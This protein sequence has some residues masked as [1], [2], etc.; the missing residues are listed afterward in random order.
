MSHF[1]VPESSRKMWLPMV[2]SHVLV[3]NLPS[4]WNASLKTSRKKPDLVPRSSDFRAS[5]AAVTGHDFPSHSWLFQKPW[6][7]DFR[8]SSVDTKHG[9]EVPVSVNQD[10]KELLLTK[11][12]E[13]PFLWYE[14]E[15][16]KE[17][18]LA[19][20]KKEMEPM[21]NFDVFSE[22]PVTSL[23][24]SELWHA[25]SSRWVKTRKPDGTVRCRLVVRG[26]D[27]VVEDPDQTFASTPSLTTLKL[28]LTLSVAF[29]WDVS[30]GDIS[31]AFL[32][33][34]ITREDIF[35]IPPAEY[36][37][38]Q[39]AVWKLKRALYGLKNFP[40][41]WQDPILHQLCRNSTLVE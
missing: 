39:N 20:M 12:L 25:I 15:F 9:L 7:Y 8:I 16:P 19:G 17:L 1:L 37:P 40:R 38:D 18:E 29:G 30:T 31:T 35:V 4:L 11:S 41:L 6:T 27:Q 14:T 23:S 24:D 22:V 21:I 33:A 26:F 2:F 32:H 28:L 5:V 36:Y 34:L 3:L 10:E 13:N